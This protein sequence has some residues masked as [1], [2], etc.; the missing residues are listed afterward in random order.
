MRT[1]AAENEKL[2]KEYSALAATYDRRWSAYIAASLQMTLDVVANLPA[3]RVLDIGCGTGQL[4]QI[5]A[6][7]SGRPELTGIDK[8]PAMLDVARQ[9][10]G[11]QA[12]LLKGD[13]ETLPFDAANFDL[14]VST[15]A[16]HYFPDAA[17]A[18]LELRRVITAPGNLVLTDWSRDYFWMRLLNRV[19][20]WTR[21][22][23][24]HT[25][26]SHELE[27]SLATAGFDVVRISRKKIDGFWG[28]MTIH[29][30]PSS[31]SIT[32]PPENRCDR[33]RR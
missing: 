19:L 21:H 18:L 20:P 10:I 16:L 7:R 4:L 24:V 9:R 28:L 2:I 14:V 30:T 6:G 15:S 11:H 22:A 13:A 32:T 26:S 1:V 3:R 5:L 27:Q 23:H 8:V 33:A 29:A 12:T 17:A 31:T 25:F